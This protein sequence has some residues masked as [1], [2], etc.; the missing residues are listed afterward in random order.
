L[1]AQSKESVFLAKVASKSILQHQATI[2]VD[3]R[4]KAIEFNVCPA[5]F[6]SYFDLIL[7]FKA[8]YSSLLQ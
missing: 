4:H 3:A 2:G 8:P 7:P 5:G 6:Q 1:Q